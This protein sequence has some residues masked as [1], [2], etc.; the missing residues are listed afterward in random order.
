MS[1]DILVVAELKDG[2]LKKSAH[3]LLSVARK[4]AG[5]LGGKAHAAVLGAGASGAAGELAEWGA[6]SV[7]AGEAPAGALA[8]VRALAGAVA[9]KQPRAVL[10]GVSAFSRDV[11]ARLAA[12]AGGALASDAIGLK[13][14]G[15]GLQVVRP[16]CAGRAILTAN[17][18]GPGPLVATL[19][20]NSF[21]IA[22]P[23]APGA[24]TVE[25]LEV[26][27]AEADLR[28]SVKEFV[29]TKSERPELTEASIVVSGGRSLGSAEHFKVIYALADAMGAAAGASR[30]AVDAGYAPHA[31]QVGQTGKTVSPALYVA[32]GISGAIQHLAGM[33]TSKYIVAINKDP[34][35]TIFKLADFG[36]VG[37]LFE[38]CPALAAEVKK[39]RG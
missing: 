27:A 16:V 35:A 24:G 7:L 10:F 28:V 19:R 15:G 32:C 22:K 20:A 23:A 3:E 34:N 6:E 30:A 1:N 38:V 18:A 25:A 37:D 29:A 11:A 9:S 14:E 26:T 31:M 5:E 8:A 2:Q 36:I 39:L 33:R 21:E 13:A 4:L 17:H 12:R